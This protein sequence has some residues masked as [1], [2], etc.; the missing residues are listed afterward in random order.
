MVDL[1]KILKNYG[2]K[3]VATEMYHGRLLV[4]KEMHEP[5]RYWFCG[6]AEV[7][8]SDHLLGID[9]GVDWTWD[10]GLSA[11]GGITFDDE[12]IEFSGKRMLGFDTN[13]PMMDNS[14]ID[15]QMI[16]NSCRE[17][18]DEIARVSGNHDGF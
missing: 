11:P 17:L 18:A 15:Y 7:L 14:K 3:V 4:V 5:T 12:L 13:H 1:D 9:D 10:V 6:Y 16:L 2:D 8:P